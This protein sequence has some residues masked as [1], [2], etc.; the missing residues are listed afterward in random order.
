MRE[1][2]RNEVTLWSAGR[3]HREMKEERTPQSLNDATAQSYH[4]IWPKKQ[5]SRG[6]WQN[7]WYSWPLIILN[8]EHFNLV[9]SKFYVQD[10]SRDQFLIFRVMHVHLSL[11]ENPAFYR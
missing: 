1:D 8:G 5:D 4:R 2:Y 6:M 3:G 9:N 10:S 7:D 11:L